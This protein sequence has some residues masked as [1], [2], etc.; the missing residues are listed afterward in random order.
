M[1][2]I[3]AAETRALMRQF[4]VVAAIGLLILVAAL[5]VGVR[6]ATFG[7]SSLGTAARAVAAGHLDRPFKPIGVDEVYTLNLAFEQMLEKLQASMGKI[8]QLAFFDGLQDCRVARSCD[9]IR[10]K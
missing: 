6:H 4:F 1:F 3:G 7:L 8:R 10:P 5:L 9:W 2:R